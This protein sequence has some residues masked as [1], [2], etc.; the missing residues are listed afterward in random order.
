MNVINVVSRLFNFSNNNKLDSLKST[1][2]K[3]AI[4][5]EEER[6]YSCRLTNEIDDL[7]SEL[8]EAKYLS[9]YH[10]ENYTNCH[11][12]FVSC[13]NTIIPRLVN[14]ILNEDNAEEVYEIIKPLDYDGWALFRASEKVT[15]ID[16]VCSHFPAED[17]RGYFASAN[18]YRLIEYIEIVK[19]ATDCTYNNQEMHEFLSGYEID[20]NSKE[21]IEYKYKLYPLAIKKIISDIKYYDLNDLMDE[22]I[23]EYDNINYSEIISDLLEY[24]VCMKIE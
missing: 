18:G 9:S 12:Q 15:G 5:L 23:R 10:Y 22:D 21:Y 6:E 17:A 4:E 14:N 3:L 8:D 16:D 24:Q 19:F 20:C 2:N 11:E 1:H 13:L 7:R